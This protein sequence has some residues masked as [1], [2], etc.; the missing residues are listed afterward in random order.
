[1]DVEILLNSTLAGGVIMGAAC[2]LIVKPYYAMLCGWAIGALSAFGY[3]YMGPWLK[4][5]ILLHDTCGIHNLHA[6]PGLFGGIVSAIA[7]NRDSIGSFGLMYG[8]NF[9]DAD[10]RTPAQQAG[11]QLAGLGVTLGIAILTGAG[12]G[13]VA[14]LSFFQPPS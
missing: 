14:N 8:S 3:A 12:A 4:E 2:D 10:T 11:M 7:C 1:L 9:I 13:F 6:L 5:K